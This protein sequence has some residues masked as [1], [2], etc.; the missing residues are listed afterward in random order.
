MRL[1]IPITSA[2]CRTSNRCGAEGHL[3]TGHLPHHRPGPR[4][5]GGRTYRGRHETRPGQP[6][7]GTASTTRRSG[8]PTSRT[9][10]SPSSTTVPPAGGRP[11]DPGGASR[12]AAPCA[13]TAAV[14]CARVTRLHHALGHR[15]RPPPPAGRSRA[16]PA[17]PQRLEHGRS[18]RGSCAP[19]R[20]RARPRRCRP[21]ATGRPRRRA[22]SGAAGGACAATT[23]ASTATAASAEAA[24]SEARSV[25]SRDARRRV[26][27]PGRRRAASRSWPSG[28]PAARSATSSSQPSATAG[29]SVQHRRDRIARAAPASNPPVRPH[30]IT[31][32]ATGTASRLAGSDATGI[33]PNVA[34]S[35]GAT[36]S[37]AASV[38]PRASRS[39]RG[40]GQDRRQP[41]RERPRW[42]A[43]RTPTAGT[44]PTRTSSGSTS[45]RPVTA[46]AITRT[47]ESGR[48]PMA[49]VVASAAIADARSTD[50]SNR[51]IT[52]NRPITASVAEQ[53]R[54][55]PQPPQHRTDQREGEGD[56]LA[57]H[58]QEV[59][60]P[61]AEEVVGQVG[62]L[63]PVVADDE[64]REQRPL[65]VVERRRARHQR[66]AQA[67]GQPGG[68][69]SR[70]PAVHPQ[71]AEAPA[72]VAGHQ[73]RLVRQ[74]PAPPCRA[75]GRPRR[76]GGPPG[77][78]ADDP[79]ARASRRRPSSRTSI[80][81]PP[82]DG[83]GI[84][85]QRDLA[86]PPSAPRGRRARRAPAGPGRWSTSPTAATKQG[87]RDAQPEPCDEAARR[88]GATRLAPGAARRPPRPSA[89]ATAWRSSI[90]PRRGRGAPRAW[91]PRSRARRAAGRPT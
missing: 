5:H 55:Q 78:V 43:P 90:T 12:S 32:P 29:R 87:E 31:S 27:P 11:T 26:R 58:R 68:R 91:P 9:V 38:T 52:P 57:G 40:P 73:P 50:G 76:P 56:V 49:R 10:R 63:V 6:D 77:R 86:R 66:A 84:A 18:A 74:A 65:A 75:P 81:N 71:H 39:A 37:C 53:A 22:T 28:A 88:R 70:P 47:R 4:V 3:R 61:G 1:R 30:T 17:P 51:V 82:N 19:R 20:R 15:R 34:S 2:R 41:G 64:A 60:E 23:A 14:G 48:P 85:E 72:H 79:S 8:T 13:T 33:G 54:P 7:R 42:R 62:R 69:V 16:T 44:R 67:V 45:S 35:T 21:R 80:R 25:R 89:T 59:G 36:P 83:V 24:R 46:T